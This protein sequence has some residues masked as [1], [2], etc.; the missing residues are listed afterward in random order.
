MLGGR[1][2]IVSLV[3]GGGM[4]EVY[5]ADDLKLGQT[6][7]LKFLARHGDSARL[8]EEVRIGRTVSHPNVCR[9]YDIAEVDGQLF[10]TM[11]F[12]D[13]EDLASL[14][15]R[16]GRLPVEKALMLTREICSGLAAAH[17]KGV[18]HRDLKPANV[19]IDGRGRARVTDFGLA[20]AAE[21]AND[22]A[23][24]PA[25][26]APEQLAGERASVKSDIYALGLVL[27][28]IF[29]GRR[30][31]EGISTNDL[32]ARQRAEFTRPTVV[33]RDVPAVI[34]R[35]IVRCLDANPEARP[36]SVEGI[37]LELPG[38][39]PLA[40]AIAAGETPS[41]A[42]VAAA[43]ERGEL[44]AAAGWSLLAIQIAGLLLFAALTA[45]T[46]LYGRFPLKSP[47]VLKERVDEVLS[48]TGQTLTR[49][50]SSAIFV[51]DQQQSQWVARHGAAPEGMSPILFFHRQSPRPMV[52]LN[53]E[54][55]VL[56]NDP[57]FLY[58]GMAD[59]ALDS[60]GHLVQLTIF[61]PQVDEPS[62]RPTKVDWTPFLNFTGLRGPMSP[63]TPRWAA[64]V[65]SDQK[66][67]WT[68]GAD[69]TRIEAAAYHGRPVWFYVI[70]PWRRPARMIE[71]QQD[72]GSR[73]STA[74]VVVLTFCFWAAAIALALRNLRRGQSD[75]RGAKRLAWSVFATLLIACLLM[76]HHVADAFDEMVLIMTSVGMVLVLTAQTWI[77][78]IAIEPLVR[79]RWP[80]MLIAAIRLLSGRVRDPMIGRDLLIGGTVGVIVVLLRQLIALLPGVPPLQFASLALSGLRYIGWFAAGELTLSIAGPI[81]FA[82]LLLGLHV[83]TRSLRVS[84]IVAGALIALVTVGDVP[85]PLWARM[86]FGLLVGAA[87]LVLLFRFGLV[88]SS[89]AFFAYLFLRR[90]PITL[91]PSAWYF[92]RSTFA[93]ALLIAIALYGFFISFGGKRW[94]PE[95]AVDA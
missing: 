61:P 30:A 28:E 77:G 46:T 19:M 47:E 64:P 20:L 65:D 9:L 48:A 2:R 45:R 16:I 57:P 43:S 34:E 4:G 38:G 33:T 10:I 22:T 66:A 36:D 40:A 27:Y 49:A 62:G 8:H 52:A 21:S 59:V 89:A 55:R 24:T 42:M 60:N 26:M 95:V 37:V 58:S 75:R 92:G 17:D 93:L 39:D 7:A 78:Y 79:R 74:V 5:R 13:G 29:T 25:Y 14:L 90:V 41:P 69:G 53:Y 70:P 50:D 23:G 44:S 18:I 51:T 94:F 82:T 54:H 71:H 88:A 32:L 84:M 15:R 56:P 83:V 91:D 31:F 85:G 6:V 72:V 67:A 87:V 76:T 80:R 3:G 73:I 12:V 68:V 1:Y 81:F 35:I 63:T 86:L 11:E